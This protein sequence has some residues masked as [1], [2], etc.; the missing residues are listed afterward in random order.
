MESSWGGEDKEPQRRDGPW[1]WKANKDRCAQMG[2]MTDS[3]GQ[4]SQR[5][6]GGGAGITFGSAGLVED[7]F[8]ES[9][10]LL[11]GGK[12]VIVIL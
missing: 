2:K 9:H 8:L 12:R 7:I 1:V 4:S 5:L 11:H 3:G 10:L 6:S